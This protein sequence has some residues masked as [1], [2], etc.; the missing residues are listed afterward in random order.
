MRAM[1]PAGEDVRTVTASRLPLR[2]WGA[3]AVAVV[4]LAVLGVGWLADSAT[5]FTASPTSGGVSRQA[6]LATVTLHV[7]PSPLQANV[8]EMFTMHVVD[9]TGK[10]VTGA[11]VTCALSM[12]AMEMSLAP[13]MATSS[14]VA[15][16]YT[17][18]T[19]LA[20]SGRWSLLVRLALA[21]QPPTHVTFAL[22]AA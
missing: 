15:G 21:G 12:P 14:K 5:S 6:G 19:R 20:H 22:E 9:V 7:A 3:V 1:T 18:D 2:R 4:A 13:T 10:P 17:C 11:A 16:D 8:P